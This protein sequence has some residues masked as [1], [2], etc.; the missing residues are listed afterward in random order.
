MTPGVSILGIQIERER[1]SVYRE[2]VSVCVGVGVIEIRAL[3]S[4]KA[5]PVHNQCKRWVWRCVLVLYTYCTRTYE[6]T[7]F[8][9]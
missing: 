1:V 7:T 4:E 2:G 9:I 6:Y 3:L 5:I 8:E